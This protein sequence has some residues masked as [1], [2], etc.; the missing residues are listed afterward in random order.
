MLTICHARR[1][2]TVHTL[3]AAAAAANGLH[4]N[5]KCHRLAAASW[6]RQAEENEAEQAKAHEDAQRQKWID[7]RL[8]ASSHRREER[9]TTSRA[10]A[11]EL[12]AAHRRAAARA[13]SR[14]DACDI[15]GKF[16]AHVLESLGA[17][18]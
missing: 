17:A 11:A 15:P 18:Y 1:Q 2:V 13:A 8:Q 14:G 4:D 10:R 7:E 3:A 9:R 16:S 12:D 5:A 6:E